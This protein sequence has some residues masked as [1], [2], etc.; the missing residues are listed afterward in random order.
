MPATLRERKEEE[1]RR[2]AEARAALEAA[3]RRHRNPVTALREAMSC[4]SETALMSYPEWMRNTALAG[5]TCGDNGCG[6]GFSELVMHALERAPRLLEAR[7]AVGG[8]P[9]LVGLQSLATVRKLWIRPL[10][11]W[12]PASKSPA[13]QFSQL[14]RHLLARYPLPLFMD[15]LLLRPQPGLREEWFHFVG[16]GGNLREARGLTPQLTKKMAHYALESPDGYDLFKAVRR[17]QVLGMGGEKRLAAALFGTHLGWRFGTK[18]EEAWWAT[19]IQWFCLHPMLDPAHVG[20]IVDYVGDR[21]R[22]DRSFSMKGR[23]PEAVLRLVEEW[24]AE[25]AAEQRRKARRAEQTF[26]ASGFQPG[27][28]PMGGGWHRRTWRME[29]IRNTGELVAEG[30]A[31]RHCVATYEDSIMDGRCAIWTLRVE[32][33]GVVERAVTV[34][35]RPRERAVVQARGK[36]NRFPNAEEAQ[37]LALWAKQNRLDLGYLGQP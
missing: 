36:F 25:L 27:E 35:V 6:A 4:F 9:Y 17:G 1:A 30:K 14:A 8:N 13:R 34:E 19:V 16:C 5:W 10:E 28:W 22:R 12:L 23:S 18:D 20:P 2:V 33:F 3:R 31:Q 32:R 11:E 24:H 29:E 7:G 21:W 26:P 15:S 37:V